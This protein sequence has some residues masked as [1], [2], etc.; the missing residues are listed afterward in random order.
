MVVVFS[1]HAGVVIEGLDKQLLSEDRSSAEVGIAFVLTAVNSLRGGS[2]VAV[3]AV[4]AS[5][6]GRGAAAT[7]SGGL[8]GPC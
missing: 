8:T 2:R 6:G 7:A 1:G 5:S 4:S 3:A